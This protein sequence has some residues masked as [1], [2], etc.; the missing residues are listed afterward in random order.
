MS[1][2]YTPVKK[3]KIILPNFPGIRQFKTS[4]IHIR[5]YEYYLIEFKTEYFLNDLKMTLESLILESLTSNLNEH[6]STR[7]IWSEWLLFAAIK[8]VCS[9]LTNEFECSMSPHALWALWLLDA[10]MGMRSITVP[11]FVWS[12]DSTK[13]SCMSDGRFA[14]YHCKNSYLQCL[15]KYFYIST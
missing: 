2:H 8:G 5:K 3:I 1:D 10:L 6:T 14:S 9:E 13:V 4:K 15:S 7:T 11:P 12:I